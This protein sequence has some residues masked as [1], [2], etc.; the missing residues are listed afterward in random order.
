MK[1]LRAERIRMCPSSE[2]KHNTWMGEFHFCL[3]LLD[4]GYLARIEFYDEGRPARA[5]ETTA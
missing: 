4:A 2:N 3:C 5:A 1:D